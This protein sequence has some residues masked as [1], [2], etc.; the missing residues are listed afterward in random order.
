MP[1]P[2]SLYPRVVLNTVDDV[3]QL[4][5]PQTGQ[6]VGWIDENGNLQGTLASGLGVTNFNQLSGLPM[7][8]ASAYGVKANARVVTDA[9][10]TNNSNQ[11]NSA[12]ANFTSSDIGKICF[13]VYSD[14]TTTQTTITGINS[15]SQA[16]MGANAVHTQSSLS[17]AYGYDD[18][19][20]LQTAFAAAV[21]GGGILQLPAGQMLVNSFTGHALFYLDYSANPNSGI[22][23]QGQ[24]NGITQF[25]PTP[26]FPFSNGVFGRGIF[27]RLVNASGF[28]PYAYLRDFSLTGLGQSLSVQSPDA[29][30]IDG[31]L[32]TCD[33]LQFIKWGATLSTFTGI[34]ASVGFTIMNSDFDGAGYTGFNSAGGNGILALNT[35]FGDCGIPVLIN[36]GAVLSMIECDI[37]TNTDSGG[38]VQNSGRLTA[39]GGIIHPTTNNALHTKSGGVSIVVGVNL[40]GSGSLPGLLT[41]SGGIANAT[42][43]LANATTNNGQMNDLGGNT[44]GTYTGSGVIGGS[45]SVTGTAFASSNVTLGAQWGSS[46]AVSSISGNTKRVQFTITAGGTGITSSPTIAITFPTSFLAA[47]ICQ[48]VQVAGTDFTDVTLPVVTTGP[49]TSGVTFTLTGTPISG[50]SYTF[51]LTADLP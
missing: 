11:I 35:F 8:Y 14:G 42:G 21:A 48:L 39:V 29:A 5:S 51:I 44:F 38:A 47:P 12:S 22:V 18:G 36:A 10:V 7:I 16:V 46:A 25:I 40:K 45:N 9:S 17:F 27:F 19:P 33:N 3:M 28:S 34:F 26:N 13:I 24:G 37:G 31:A 23:I 2:Y 41:D 30:I 1:N 32:I 43:T 20:A 49:S 15:S 6:V 50:D 4:V